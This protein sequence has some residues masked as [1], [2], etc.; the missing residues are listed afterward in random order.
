MDKMTAL[1]IA[2]NLMQVPCRLGIGL[3]SL[4]TSTK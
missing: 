2:R 1:Q 4:W 3:A